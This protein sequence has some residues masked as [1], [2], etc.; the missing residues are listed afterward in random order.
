MFEKVL[1]AN[2]GEIALRVAR[3][4][5]ELGIKTVGVYSTA[6]QDSAVLR[7]VDEQVRIGPPPSRQSYMNAAAVVEA[8]LRTGAQAV[9]P[10]YGFLS[11][12]PDFAE[13]CAA[14][15]LTFI[16]PRPEVM[17][18]LGNKASARALMQD[19]GLPLLPG[20]VEG[21]QSATEARELADSIGYP[22]I[23]KAAAGGGGRGMAVIHDPDEVAPTYLEIRATAQALFGDPTVYLERYL[24]RTRHVEVQVLC[25]GHGNGVHLG[26][27]DC[28]AQRRNQKLIEEA[29]APNLRPEVLE[30]VAADAVRGALAVDFSG[31]GTFEFLVDPDQNHY[32]MEINSRIQVEHPVTEMV[33]GI[34]LIHEQLHVA[35]GGELRLAQDDIVL[36]GVSLECR[37]NAEDPARGFV[38]TPGT[39]ERFTPPGGPFTRVDTHGFAGYRVSPHYDSLLAK[40]IVWAP[41]RDE[42]IA[43]M[44]RALAEFDLSGPGVKTTLPALRQILADPEFRAAEHSTALVGRLLPT[45]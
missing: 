27:R 39:L 37:V 2:R 38:P 29:P 10:G 18:S 34:D 5:R 3:A 42:A 30:A 17:E 13:I 43:R 26:T 14:N 9:H 36:R 7:H 44:D 32:F 8:A 24:E 25:D 41:G 16:G 45:P 40:V 21:V 28:S 35:S 33:S 15:D 20:S 4:C 6:D 1:I 12:D 19:A 31:V 22:V 23:L 11:E